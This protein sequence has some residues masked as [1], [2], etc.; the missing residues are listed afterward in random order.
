MIFE[1][2]NIAV[3]LVMSVFLLVAAAVVGAGSWYYAYNEG[4]SSGRN[5]GF[6]DGRAKGIEIGAG[7]DPK[8]IIRK[9]P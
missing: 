2:K 1:P 4:Y 8:D 7:Y 5:D 6:V 3:I 9:A